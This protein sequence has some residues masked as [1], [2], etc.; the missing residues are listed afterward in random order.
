M[1]AT[2][3]LVPWGVRVQ[4]MSVFITMAMLVGTMAVLRPDAAGLPATGELSPQPG[5]EQVGLTRELV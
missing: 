4:T 3:L 1:L 2:A 5:L